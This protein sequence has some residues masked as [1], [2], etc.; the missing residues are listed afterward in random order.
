MDRGEILIKEIIYYCQMIEES[1]KYFGKDEKDFMDDEY[2]QFACAYCVLQIEEYADSFVKNSPEL[3]E[4]YPEIEWIGITCMRNI[5]TDGGS[6]MDMGVL[7]KTI[8]GEV[9]ALKAACK[10]AVREQYDVNLSW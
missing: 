3:R 6:K 9:P 1:L 10:K 5:I 2:F 8:T 4:E 7:W